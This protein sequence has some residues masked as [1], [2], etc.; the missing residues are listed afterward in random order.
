[1]G[2]VNDKIFLKYKIGPE[3]TIRLF[4]DKFVEKYKNICTI[5]LKGENEQ[6][7]CPNYKYNN[8][9]LSDNN[10]LEIKLT[11]VNEI[12]DASYMFFMC[13]SLEIVKNLQLLNTSNFTTLCSMFDGCTSLKNISDISEWNTEKIINMNCLFYRCESL[14][15]IPDIS[16]WDTK[17][18]IN[19]H[20]IFSQCK[21]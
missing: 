21:S 1:M 16:K 8:N 12:K 14:N 6:E 11:G 17:N 3:S 18:V 2:E 15:R 20:S 13:S 7:L 5:I 19:I 9:D 10:T 4:G